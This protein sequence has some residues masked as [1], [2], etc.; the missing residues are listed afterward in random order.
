[1]LLKSIIQ[2]YWDIINGKSKPR[3]LMTPY[4]SDEA[5]FQHI[6]MFEKAFPHYRLKA[7]D[8]IEENDRVVVRARFMGTHNG[9]FN[10]IEPTGKSVDLPFIII[11]R[12]EGGKIAEH[13]LETNHLS[14]LTQL[15]VMNKEAEPA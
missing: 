10:G 2:D 6:E 11:Y 7:E 8:M 12:M 14:L 9:D 3:E 15:G 4:V 1:M 5:L 13:W